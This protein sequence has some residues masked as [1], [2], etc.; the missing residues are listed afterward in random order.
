MDLTPSA[1]QKKYFSII[2]CFQDMT[3]FKRNKKTQNQNLR[4]KAM[5]EIYC[6]IKGCE[7]YMRFNLIGISTQI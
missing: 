1:T 6:I 2:S 5:C 3:I 7:T 4:N